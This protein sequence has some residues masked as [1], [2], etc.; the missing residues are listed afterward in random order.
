MK[1]AIGYTVIVCCRTAKNGHRTAKFLPH[2][3]DP[4]VVLDLVLDLDL[5]PPPKAAAVRGVIRVSA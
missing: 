5:D 3:Q 4:A 2:P 1:S